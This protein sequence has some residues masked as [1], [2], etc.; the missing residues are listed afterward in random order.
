MTKRDTQAREYA[1]ESYAKADELYGNSDTFDLISDAN[2][3]LLDMATRRVVRTHYE[4]CRK[5]HVECLVSAM[6]QDMARLRDATLTDSERDAIRFFAT[7]G[8]PAHRA[9][10]L[11]KILERLK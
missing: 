11:R 1:A 4:G 7:Y 8:A 9:S 10:T 6:V 5:N 3:F 2:E